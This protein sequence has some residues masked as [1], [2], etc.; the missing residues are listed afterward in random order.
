M[1]T[2]ENP[3]DR[4]DRE[5]AKGPPCEFLDNWLF[6]EV[7]SHLVEDPGPVMR[8]ATLLAKRAAYLHQLGIS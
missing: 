2:L 8:L 4:L 5:L 3:L 7:G 1:T 6:G